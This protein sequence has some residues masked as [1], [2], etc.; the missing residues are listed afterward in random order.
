MN[1]MLLSNN[2]LVNVCIVKLI[3]MIRAAVCGLFWLCREFVKRCHN[4]FYSPLH[5]KFTR[6]GGAVFIKCL[7]KQNVTGGLLVFMVPHF[8]GRPA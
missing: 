5:K 3:M 1:I 2:V 4:W 6:C 7:Y 8:Y